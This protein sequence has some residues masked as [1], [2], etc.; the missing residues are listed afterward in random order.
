MQVYLQQL[1]I[2]QK[3]LLAVSANLFNTQL[4][5]A[6]VNMFLDQ[7]SLK[8]SFKNVSDFKL[9]G[10][11]CIFL[12]LKRIAHNPRLSPSLPPSLTRKLSAVIFL[13][14]RTS[15]HCQS[16]VNLC[17]LLCGRLLPSVPLVIDEGHCVGHAQDDWG[18][19]GALGGG[20]R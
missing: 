6:A 14:H 11:F 8:L 10:K 20:I 17:H 7:K 5:V 2:F 12:S 16:E 18:W 19:G 15:S 3:L 4:C 1:Q 9:P 13:W